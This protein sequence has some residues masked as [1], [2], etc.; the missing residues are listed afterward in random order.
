MADIGGPFDLVDQ[1]GK[2]VT[3]RTY[4]GKTLMV[5]FGYTNCPD[6]CPTGLAS[7]SAVLDDL[8]PD[9]GRVQGLFISVDPARDTVAVLKD[10]IANFNPRIAALTGTPAQIARATA[11]YKVEYRKV[12]ADGAPLPAAST[13]TDYAMEHNAAIFLM[14]PDGHLRSAIN[15]FDPPAIAEG[16]VRHALGLPVAAN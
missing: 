3:D 6:V 7:M 13:A 14:D 16:K 9:A 5:L 1:D 8:G 4:A 11:S 12:T 2:P 10:Y 15:P